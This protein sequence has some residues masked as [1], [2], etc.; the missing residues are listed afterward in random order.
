M[1]SRDVA[2]ALPEWLQPFVV[3]DVTDDPA[4]LNQNLAHEAERSAAPAPQAETPPG[5]SGGQAPVEDV[6]SPTPSPDTV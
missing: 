1:P 6:P 3:R 2:A 4:Y 5:E